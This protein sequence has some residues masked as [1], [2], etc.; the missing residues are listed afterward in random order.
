M[1][2]V[3]AAATFGGLVGG[4]SA[5]R[6]VALFPQGTL[7]PLLGSRRWHLCGRGR[8]SWEGER[9]TAAPA[10]RTSR[11]ALGLG[12][13]PA[14]AAVAGP[15][16]RHRPG[17]DARGARG[18][19]SQGRG[20]RLFREGSA[21]GALLRTVLRRDRPGRGVDAGLRRTSRARAARPRRLGGEP[22]G[23]GG[24][25]RPARIRAAVSV[26]RHPSSRRSTW[27]FAARR[28][29]PATSCSTRRWRKRPSVRPSRSSTW[30]V[31]A[32]ERARAP[33]LILLIV[34][35]APLH[36]FAA[37][38]LAVAL[39]AAGEFL[40][41]RRLRAGYVSALE[42]GL[43]RQGEH[44]AQAVEYSMADFTVARSMTGL[45]RA[46]VLRALGSPDAVAVD[47]RARRSGR[48]GD[49][50]VPF[51]R[52]PAHSRRAARPPARSAHHRRRWCSCWRGT[53]SCARVTAALAAFGARAAGEMVSVLL[54]PATPDVIRRRLPLALKSCPSPIARD[55]LWTALDG[56]RLRD[57]AALR[58]RAAGADG[59]T[60]R[61]P[62]VR[63]PTRWRSSSES[64]VAAARRTS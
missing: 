32:P 31:I 30:P 47:R 16:A 6:V 1:A 17:G 39:A 13:V 24:S 34:G 59:R 38:N 29:V 36:P 40:V 10:S 27:S 26:A 25:G 51:R 37:V 44:L 58:A 48:R 19:S 41:A 12:A 9:P 50:R 21:A 42:G 8:W 53:T 33:L 15:G 64:S 61:A 57:P 60:P 49:H 63:S 4:V 28:S 14:A 52:P 3:A 20:G 23:R 45:D 43:R 2:R 5:E 35:L 54:D 46:A 11:S 56:I 55:G 22:P 62:E 18:L 7:L